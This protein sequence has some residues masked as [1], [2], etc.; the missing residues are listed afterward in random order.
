MPLKIKREKTTIT[1]K[2]VIEGTLLDVDYQDVEQNSNIR[3]F[4]RTKNGIESF[5]HPS[6]RPYFYAKTG[7]GFKAK[8]F[9]EKHKIL[10]IRE[11]KLGKEKV[12]QLFC[13]TTTQL[14]TLRE[15]LK[16]DS[17]IS[18]TFETDIPFAKRYLID[19]SLEPFNGVRLTLN[20]K[21]EIE[22]VQKNE[23][24]YELHAL[25]FD[26][27]TYSPG[28]FSNAK[29]D[30]I[31]TISIVTSTESVVLTHHEKGK[32]IN[33]C[34]YFKTEKEM[35]QH[36]LSYVKEFNPDVLVTYNGDSF[37]FPY[38]R[39]R[40]H[41]NDLVCTL[42]SDQ[43]EFEMGRKGTDSAA[44]LVGRQHLDVFQLMSFLSRFQ[45]INLI[46]YDLESVGKALLG[47]E[48][49]KL[50][51]KDINKIWE[52]GKDFPELVRYNRED[53]EMTLQLAN[54]Y[55]PLT[56][57]L[58]KISHQTLYDASRLTGGMLV[59]W[60]LIQKAHEQQVLVPNKPAETQVASRQNHPIEG[61]FVKTPTA[62][63]HEHIVV[64]D[65]RSLYPS[66]MISHNVSPETLD[67][68][69]EPGAKKNNHSP[70]GHYFSLKENGFI[71][72]NMKELLETRSG[73][74]AKM[75]QAVGTPQYDIL[76]AQSWSLKIAL[77]SFYGYL[78]FARS[79]WY[80][81]ECGESIT[82]WAREYIQ[83]VAREAEQE[84][85]NVLYG[86]T[87]SCFFKLPA[88]KTK[89]DAKRFLDEINAKLPKPMEL[90]LDGFYKRGIFVTQKGSTD[91]A[92]KKRYALMGEDGKLKIVGFEYVR[93]DWST[94]A[95][96]TQKAVID[97]V[98]KDGKPQEAIRIVRETIKRL[99][100]GKVPKKELVVYTQLTKP[101][102]KYDTTGPHVEA[103]RKAQEKGIKVETGSVIAFIITKKGESI[104]EKA[105]T[106][107]FV[108]EG[109]YDAEYYIKH[110]VIP[111][112]AH[113]LREL[114]CSEE[115]LLS[116]G[117]QQK[118]F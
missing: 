87:D 60:M 8:N 95:K 35:L 115:D 96:E 97:A 11:K 92:A 9:Q 114:G 2:R 86:D 74:K 83:M 21:N 67:P 12:Q 54:K 55:W 57:Q 79:R 113:I 5:I 53:S 37:D 70:S 89:E 4:V 56:M 20:E 1:T 50:S 82:A 65:F 59:E 49:D 7:N 103:A 44:N 94:I 108:T 10:E 16:N 84:G 101:V 102:N 33:G 88:N 111:A 100:S 66:I 36:F 29:K 99:R 81:R 40:C 27:E 17:T 71:A 85:F 61:A 41:Q 64:M 6:F 18:E 76:F 46:K 62:G 93:R 52:T 30:P 75:K 22:T 69:N 23:K 38:I 19:F 72:R 47:I 104:S 32:G 15:Q 26:L 106:E 77:N 105:V 25:A 42:N 78:L 13:S 24:L 63:L 34:L 14:K 58:C 91:T 3:V 51:W 118:L 110:Q 43:T 107:D 90:E 98:L 80:S 31:L 48:K 112:V 68:K 39:Q 109:D 117:Q 116:G 73:L 45:V 28:R